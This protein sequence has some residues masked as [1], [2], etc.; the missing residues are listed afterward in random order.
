MRH[1]FFYGK[2]KQSAEKVKKL[3]VDGE[4]TAARK[5]HP[6]HKKLGWQGMIALVGGKIDDFGCKRAG[7]R[8]RGSNC[9]FPTDVLYAFI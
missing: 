1:S 4:A 3:R 5:G 7:G 8:G 9:V 2:S 6:L